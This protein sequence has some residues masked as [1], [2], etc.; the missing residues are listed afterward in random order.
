MEAVR[1]PRF[2]ADFTWGA[3]TSSYQIEGAIHEGGRGESI[4]DRFCDV[5]GKVL[6]R[7]NGATA[8]D[9]YHRYPDDILLMRELGI[10]SFRFSIAWPRILPNGT[11]AVNQAGLDF[12]DRLVDALLEAGIAPCA[13]L[14]HW[15][16]PVMLEDI[17]GWP[18]RELIGPFAEYTEVVAAR[19]GD[20]VTRWITH[21][22]PWVIGWLGYGKGEHAPGLESR[23][24]AL[25]ASHTLLVSH[26]HAVEV[27]RNLSPGSE[28]GITLNLQPVFPADDTEGDHAAA[29]Y[30]DGYHNR[31]YLD[32]LYKGSYP[33][34]MLELYGDD[35]PDVLDGDMALAMTPTDY[36][37]INYYT[38]HVVAEGASA[39]EP[40]YIRD[41]DADYTT[42]GW[43]VYPD[44]LRALLVSLHEDYAPPALQITE[45]GAAYNDP[46]PV[47]GIVDDPERAAYY[48]KHV[49]AMG[50]AIE[51]G[52]PLTAYY[53]WSLMDNF[54]WAFGYDQR[55]GL[56]HVDFDTLERTP[57][58]SFGFYRDQ[59]AAQTLV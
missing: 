1:D 43:E 11:G 48:A 24:L 57:K 15:D 6:N 38:R 47:G 7:D 30:V 50:D 22:E 27:L 3:A 46:A 44:G 12:Y 13:T 56:I 26:G 17:G 53:A 37:G 34:D 29:R 52:V 8:C 2:P 23:K 33:A 36:L 16:L 18:S 14:Y 19:L 32:P 9:F 35:A 45:N 59:I 25:A 10:T 51:A 54:E 5:P 58:A 41:P 42:M 40:R 28:V 49:T 20:R 4:W 21:N 31:W 55:F 39:T